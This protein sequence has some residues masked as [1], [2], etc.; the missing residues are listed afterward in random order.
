[1]VAPDNGSDKSMDG[2]AR[3]CREIEA[4]GLRQSIIDVQAD[5]AIATTFFEKL[6]EAAKQQR[7]R[8]I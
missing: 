8:S 5:Q 6:C 1:M 7:G 2:S 3:R 4:G